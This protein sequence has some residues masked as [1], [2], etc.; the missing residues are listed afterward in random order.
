MLLTLEHF[1]FLGLLRKQTC[2]GRVSRDAGI[3]WV[4]DRRYVIARFLI[5]YSSMLLSEVSEEAFDAHLFT[6]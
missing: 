3:V 5:C 2:L 4:R 6:K 1:S